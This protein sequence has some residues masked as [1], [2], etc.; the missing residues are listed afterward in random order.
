[1]IYSMS[2]YK[3]LE[4]ELRK[5]KKE[6]ETNTKENKLLKKQ[7][8]EKEEIIKD[9]DRYDYRGR[10][11]DLKKENEEL[12]KKVKN[13]EELLGLLKKSQKSDSSNSLKPSSTNGYKQ[14]TQNNREK[15]GRK[16]GREKGHEK[17]A[18]TV[19]TNPDETVRVSKVATC[20]CGH[21]TV[22]KAEVARDLISVEVITHITQYVGYKT[23]CPCCHKQY[24]PKFP[25]NVKNPR[26]YAENVKAI[27][28]YLNTY[29][30]VPNLKTTEFLDFLSDGKINMAPATVLNIL[31]QFS[32]KSEPI[33]KEMKEEIL[34]EAVI[35]EDETPIEVNGKIMST[36]G[37]FTKKLSILEAFANRKLESFQEMGILDRYIGTVC[38][39]HNKIHNSFIQSTQAECNFHIL[40]YCKSEYGVHKRESIK[41]FM[42]YMLE[43][44]DEVDKHKLEGKTSFSEGEY[45]QAKEEYLR[46]LDKWDKEYSEQTK[47]SMSK[48]YLT[49]RNLKKRLREYVD[50]HLRF[51]TDF[52][53]DFTNNLAERGLRPIKKKLKIAGCFRSLT[54]AKHYCHA[55]SIIDTG[56]KQNLNIGQL[57]IDVLKGKKK[58]F[59]YAS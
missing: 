5:I 21:K 25:D 31:S 26:N 41:E 37:V 44:R 36:I 59:S 56:K 22:E 4:E 23:E 17:S 42:N 20:T 11:Q 45:K 39:D 28:T 15:T 6:Q 57:I 40:R 8:K 53:I 7:I 30:N 46:K 49:E 34:K 51:L 18:P 54:Y 3:M 32:K 52:R 48:Y 50:D 43:L 2:Q 55:M 16:P 35:N 27:A 10:Y 12:K 58:V 19:S 9:L 47:N 29:C 38:H 1:M 33:I 13:L 24:M 14:V